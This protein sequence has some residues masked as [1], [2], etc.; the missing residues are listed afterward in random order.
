MFRA[1]RPGP[2]QRPEVESEGTALNA[3]DCVSLVRDLPGTLPSVPGVLLLGVVMT[4]TRVRSAPGSG[5]AKECLAIAR[6][7]E[8]HCCRFWVEHQREAG[9][10]RHQVRERLT[11]RR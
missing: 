8:E 6:R 1:G 2:P 10:G 4:S 3:R 5:L 7:H 11:L 9:S